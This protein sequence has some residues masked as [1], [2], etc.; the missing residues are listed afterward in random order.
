MDEDDFEPNF[1]DFEVVKLLY[2]TKLSTIWI[3]KFKENNQFHIL[4]GRK[5]SEIGYKD[6]EQLKSERALLEENKD[7]NFPKMIKSYKDDMNL[8]MLLDFK[9][10]LELN[11]FLKEQQKIPI[12]L[13]FY[14]ASQMVELL[15][16]LK[17]SNILYRDLKLNN[18]LI[19]NEFKL[20][21]IDFGFAKKLEIGDRTYT[22]CGTYHC[23]APEILTYVFNKKEDPD[24]ID[25]GSDTGYGYEVD[26]Y[27]FGIFLY[28]LYYGEPPYGY[29]INSE[30]Y[31]QVLLGEI[32]EKNT[33][34]SDKI[35]LSLLDLIK[36]TININP[37]KRLTIEEIGKHE[38][39]EGNH[40]VFNS[41]DYFGQKIMKQTWFDKIKKDIEFEGNFKSSYI[42]RK[43]D[44]FEKYF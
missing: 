40:R 39:F 11:I 12:E 2:K 24:G 4:K 20:K 22:I 28:E 5:K 14:I 7:D 35:E 38:F 19:D 41:Q 6:F 15:L 26:V 17:S 43:D 9:E 3:V 23:M 25:T 30:N 44:I 1:S 34:L 13:Y 32:N 10:G 8:Y 27:S 36:K 37:E 29:E 21:L 18:V 42:D 16:T 31:T 33:N